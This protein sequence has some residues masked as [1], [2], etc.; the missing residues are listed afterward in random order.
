MKH[1]DPI[2]I[3]FIVIVAALITMTA[4]FAHAQQTHTL[5]WTNPPPDATHSA[6]TGIRIFRRASNNVSFGLV[7]TV[8]PDTTT[9][10]L[11]LPGAAPD[12]RHCYRVQAFNAAG[13]SDSNEACTSDAPP[14]PEVFAPHAP[15]TLTATIT[16]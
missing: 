4:T 5:S 15:L 13:L 2:D 3:F 10:T 12:D 8:N 6:P 7:T 1:L 14:T 16:D 11:D 9:Y